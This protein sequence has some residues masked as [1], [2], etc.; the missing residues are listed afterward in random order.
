M[1]NGKCPDCDYPA[2]LGFKDCECT[3]FKCKFYV[4][5]LIEPEPAP[6]EFSMNYEDP[7]S[8][9]GGVTPS[10]TVNPPPDSSLFP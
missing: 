10:T 4:E 1:I 5:G 2:Y 3:N 6:D 7:S 8:Y 9:G